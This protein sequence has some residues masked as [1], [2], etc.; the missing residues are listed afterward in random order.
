MKRLY[1]EEMAVPLGAASVVKLES[2]SKGIVRLPVLVLGT[3]TGNG[4]IYPKEEVERAISSEAFKRACDNGVLTCSADGH[5]Q[6][7]FPR[8]T[9]VSHL[10][11][12]AWVDSYDGQDYLY[13]EWQLLD[14]DSGRNLRAVLEAGGAVGVSVRGLATAKPVEIDGQKYDAMTEY[15]FLGTDAV[16]VPAA[17]LWVGKSVPRVE[18]ESLEKHE[19]GTQYLV[20]N[21]SYT[22]TG[23]TVKELPAGYYDVDVDPP[24]G[25]VFSKHPNYAEALIQFDDPR[26]TE[27]MRNIQDFWESRNKYDDA[28]IAYKRGILLYGK[29]GTGKTALIEQIAQDAVQRGHIVLHVRN[30]YLALPAL[31]EVHKIE[32][33]R[34]RLVV[35]EEIDR[36]ESDPYLRVLDSSLESTSNTVFIGTTNYPEKLNPAL[37]RPGR[38]DVR[39]EIGPPPEAGRRAYFSAYFGEDVDDVVRAT[40]GLTFGEM[41]EILVLTRIY[42]KSLAEAVEQVTGRQMNTGQTAVEEN[43]YAN[44]GEWVRAVRALLGDDADIPADDSIDAE[45]MD[46][47]GEVVAFWD[48]STGTGYVQDDDMDAGDELDDDVEDDELEESLTEEERIADLLDAAESV[49]EESDDPVAII[50]QALED[51]QSIT[52][53]ARLLQ[54]VDA[55]V[56]QFMEE[57]DDAQPE[58]DEDRRGSGPAERIRTYRE[59]APG[60]RIRTYQ[61][62]APGERI[63]TY[64]EEVEDAPVAE[65]D[66]AL[67]RDAV[68]SVELEGLR[69]RLSRAQAYLEGMRVIAERSR[70]LL[71][72]K[73]RMLEKYQAHAPEEVQRAA[74]AVMRKNGYLRNFREEL[75]EARSPQEVYARAAKYTNIPRHGKAPEMVYSVKNRDVPTERFIPK[76]FK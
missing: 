28:G 26:Y 67:E 50:T 46:D 30:P 20:Q 45:I 17:N 19:E 38:F 60:E 2:L 59:S 41:R 31:D 21:D 14:T 69:V 39:V 23:D 48:A 56:A 62:A 70:Q 58:A 73:S 27:V 24:R 75:M 42:G 7:A 54:R 47:S 16:S 15:E 18:M 63:R 5:P 25:I 35:F 1:H 37:V 22:P 32:P 9:D 53:D 43:Q 57:D 76:G 6:D 72:R 3:P 55:W 4:R 49:L 11:R 68:A 40:D 12:K 52:D 36:E 64:R 66:G 10:V 34:G 29:P 74:E 13:N 65:E 44:H 61:E 33:E 8:P 71:R 51:A